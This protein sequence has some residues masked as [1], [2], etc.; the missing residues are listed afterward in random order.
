MFWG[1]VNNKISIADPIFQYTGIECV[2]FH[3][4]TPQVITT[5]LTLGIYCPTNYV[6]RLAKMPTHDAKHTVPK[7]NS[8]TRRQIYDTT[9][10]GYHDIKLFTTGYT[11]DTVFHKSVLVKR[12][13]W[14]FINSLNQND[15][16][17]I[18]TGYGGVQ[19]ID[20]R[21]RFSE[22]LVTF[23]TLG[24]YCPVTYT[25]KFAYLDDEYY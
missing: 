25:Y 17:P 2:Y 1:L 7:Y 3:I 23:L 10:I 14:G 24:I 9:A 12:M 18:S 19:S 5:V 20:I 4:T 22:R 13:A 6:Y 16:V 11:H 21:M 8:P 15:K